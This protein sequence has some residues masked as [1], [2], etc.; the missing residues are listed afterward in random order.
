MLGLEASS[1]SRSGEHR[2]CDRNLQDF[3][4]A[5]EKVE[6]PRMDHESSQLQ[7]LHR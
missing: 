3:P 6:K 5:L 4:E 2:G 7:A 1:G